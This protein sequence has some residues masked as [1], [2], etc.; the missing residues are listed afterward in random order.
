MP[1]LFEDY[2]SVTSQ[3][4][5]DSADDKQWRQKNNAEY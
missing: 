2:W 3:L 1:F 5:R 4:D